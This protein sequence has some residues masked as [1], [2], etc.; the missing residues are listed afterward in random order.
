MVEIS[1]REEELPEAVIGKL[2]KIAAEDKSI[3]SLGPGEPDFSLPKPLVNYIPQLKN[4]V[5]HYSPPA[6]R[7]DLREAIAKKVR[8]E[9][10]IKASPEM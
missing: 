5:N 8:K 7:S 10:K 9:N 3:A 4:K 1:E 6:G 2:L